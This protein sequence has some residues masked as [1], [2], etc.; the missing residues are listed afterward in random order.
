MP[1]SLNVVFKVKS[2]AVVTPDGVDYTEVQTTGGLA[3]FIAINGPGIQ[4]GSMTVQEYLFFP[5][6]SYTA[7]PPVIAPV[8]AVVGL[9]G[10]V[11]RGDPRR[12]VR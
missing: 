9:G 12:G 1:L 6:A 5:I 8:A 7:G 4:P 3:Q 10:G 2:S 11:R